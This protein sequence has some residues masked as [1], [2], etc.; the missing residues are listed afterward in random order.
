MDDTAND[1]LSFDEAAAWLGV[2]RQTI[3]AIV[4]ERHELRPAEERVI[5]KQRRR[6]FRR[7]DVEA[8]RRKR[9]GQTTE[10]V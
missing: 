5:G 7:G 2:S 8:L 9:E 1:L 4:N 6:Y 3:Y 10:N